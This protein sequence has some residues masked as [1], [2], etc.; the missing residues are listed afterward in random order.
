[1]IYTKI[2]IY[3]VEILLLEVFSP[4]FYYN[5]SSDI[6]IRCV[7]NLFRV[8]NVSAVKYLCTYSKEL[9]C[10]NYFQIIFQ[11]ALLNSF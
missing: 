8:S 4:Y 10:L 9:V 5:N 11:H 2:E 6:S 7:E 1:M 3:L